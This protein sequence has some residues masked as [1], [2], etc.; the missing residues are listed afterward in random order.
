MTTPNVQMSQAIVY[1]K[2][3]PDGFQVKVK[4]ADGSS[5]Q[6]LVDNLAQVFGMACQNLG[7]MVKT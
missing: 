1:I 7:M 2:R 3:D 6:G 5:A 4:L